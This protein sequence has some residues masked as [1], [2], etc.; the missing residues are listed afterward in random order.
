MVTDARTLS[1]KPKAPICCSCSWLLAPTGK[2]SAV[3]QPLEETIT[4]LVF[5]H[6]LLA[7][8]PQG[9]LAANRRSGSSLVKHRA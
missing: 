5:L 7:G 4:W 9:W 8:P 3:D 2:G 1:A 6:V